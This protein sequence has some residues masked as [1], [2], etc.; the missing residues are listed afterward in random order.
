[1]PLIKRSSK[2][3]R[4]VNVR[5]LIDEG[6]PP[7]Q[8]VAIAYATQRAARAKN[9]AGET[10]S[11]G[12]AYYEAARKKAVAWVN[13]NQPGLTG[14]AWYA[15]VRDAYHAILDRGGSNMAGGK[16]HNRAG[17][18]PKAPRPPAGTPTS[19]DLYVLQKELE[20]HEKR[21]GQPQP[22]NAFEATSMGAIRKMLKAGY[23][24]PAVG[25]PRGYWVTTGLADSALHE[26]RIRHAGVYGIPA[27]YGQN[28]AGGKRR[29]RAGTRSTARKPS[30]RSYAERLWSN[31]DD[32]Q[33][34]RIDYE[35]FG[36]RNRRIWSEVDAAGK[37]THEGVLK[38]L[39]E[40][41][42]KGPAHR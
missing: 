18:Q 33:N 35:T 13:K 21:N 26:W 6:Y 19:G 42:R 5:R 34:H 20:L 25:Y 10:L 2:A 22:L 24:A 29:N 36:D 38:L 37:A 27:N 23:L 9:K 4:A 39:R 11:T 31:A 40:E 15:A 41:I 30:A 7:R 1:M 28:A 16:R 12:P 17:K 14:P 8:A 32:F 3:A